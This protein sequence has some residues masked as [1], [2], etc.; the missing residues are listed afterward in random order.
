MGGLS[1]EREVSLS[2]GENV[3][4]ALKN[5]SYNVTRIE[6]SSADQLIPRLGELELVFI[7]LHGWIGEDGTVQALLDVLNKPYTGS[8]ALACR[9]AMDKLLAKEAFA[10]ARLPTPCYMYLDDPHRPGEAIEAAKRFGFPLVVKPRAE[11]SSLGV[12][13]VRAPEELEG[14]LRETM[15][16]FGEAF[17]EQFTSGK[18]IT[19]GILRIDQEDRALPLIEL[20][21][22]REFYNYEA[23]YTPGATE[24]IIPADLDKET[25]QTIQKLALAA[26]RALGCFGFSRV[27]LRVTEEGQPYILEVNTVPGMTETSDLPQAAQAAGISFENLVD[28]MCKTA[29]EKEGKYARSI[30]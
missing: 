24:F 7:C 19:A 14:A 23:K 21:P 10:K 29:L 15:E 30:S 13:I 12:R 27:D 8:P 2:S 18:E 11:G 22:R 4:Q 16:R 1:G 6:I 3:Y 28:C 17:I 5:A 20:R 9:R 25:A 26:H